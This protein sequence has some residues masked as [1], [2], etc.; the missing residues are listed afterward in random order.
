MENR[1]RKMIYF[2][3]EQRFS[4][5]PMK[6]IYPL[7][8]L[9]SVGPLAYGVYQ[10]LVLGKPWGDN[11]GSDTSL[12]VI[13]LS[14]FAFM[15]LLGVFFFRSRLETTIDAEGI[16]YRFPLLIRKWRTI[17]KESIVRYEVRKYSPLLE[18][19]GWGYRSIRGYRR[20]KN[21]I[22][23]NVKGKI[24]LQLYF[25]NGTKM[26]IGTQRPTAVERA[27]KKLMEENKLNND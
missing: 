16:H 24:G 14:I 18:Y 22:A 21:G 12:L 17:K 1:K 26:L 19:G 3:E 2:S 13:F 9:V 7:I 15:A 4:G 10:Q 11:P 27:M 6:W 8:F 25:A 23:Y 20:R 5:S